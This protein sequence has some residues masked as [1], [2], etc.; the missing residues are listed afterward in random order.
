ML[1]KD[2][3]HEVDGIDT[4]IE[5]SSSGEFGITKAGHTVDDITEI[6]GK[7]FDLSDD[8]AG[9]DIVEHLAHRQVT[10]PDSLG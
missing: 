5:Q 8:S 1:S 10:R 7:R 3:E 2:H 4:D 9:E 6:R